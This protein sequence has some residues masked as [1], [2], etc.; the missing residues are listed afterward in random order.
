MSISQPLR[1]I[2]VVEFA[3]IGPAPFAAMMLA[4]LGASVLRIE[5]PGPPPIDAGPVD[6]LQRHRQESRVLDLKSETGREA[7]RAELRQADALIEGFRPGVM[8]RLGLGPDECMRIQPR[9]VYGRVT[10]W[11]RDGPLAQVAGHDINYLALTGM[12]GAMGP[13]DG[14]PMPPLNL[15]ADFGGGG[16]LLTVG[17]ISALLRT[18]MGGEG[19]V[20]DAAMLDGAALLG[21][22]IFGLRAG[23]KWPGPR[24]A[25]ML[26]GG[27]P[28][29]RCYRCA[30]GKHVAVGAIEAPFYAALLRGLN[31]TD[32]DFDEQWDRSAWPRMAIKLA[33]LF[34]TA[35][36]EHWCRLLEGTDACLSPVLTLDE[37]PNH[38]H[39]RARRV[40][41]PQ[42]GFDEPAAAPRFSER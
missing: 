1:G 28:F 34:A 6:I 41:E 17:I 16:M 20:V 3:A 14:P 4:D 27:A 19:C 15:V 13:G 26:D 11:G 23:G 8:E 38:P 18:R 42:M 25:N 2:R 22:S 29:Y 37:A 24:G 7:V 9:L 5:R 33:A 35:D 36:R 40:F 30:D 21:A 12:L 32:P 10:G 31:I 39:N